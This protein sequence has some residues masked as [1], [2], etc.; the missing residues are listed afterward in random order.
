MPIL[1]QISVNDLDPIQKRALTQL[2]IGLEGAAAEGLRT[3]LNIDQDIDAKA[4]YT[5]VMAK[6]IQATAVHQSDQKMVTK[7]PAYALIMG[8]SP[9][10]IV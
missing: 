3:Q 9:T 1:N 8:K 4:T 7:D 10:N 2:L 5:S 6:A